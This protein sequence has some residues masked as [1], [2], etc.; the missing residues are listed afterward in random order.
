ML[1]K[2]KEVTS[3]V[4]QSDLRYKPSTPFAIYSIDVSAFFGHQLS[5]GLGMR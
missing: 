5:L 2:K 4:K 3:L 1:S